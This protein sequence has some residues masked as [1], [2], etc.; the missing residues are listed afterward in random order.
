M[1]SEDV[2]ASLAPHLSEID[3]PKG[4]NIYEKGGV[5]DTMYIIVEGQ[6]RVHDGENNIL[7]LLGERDF[8][9]ELTTLDPQPHAASTTANEDTRLLGL[10]RD[11]LYELMSDYP[12]ML[13][14]IVQ[15][16][17]QRLRGKQESS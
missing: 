8:F 10:N 7:V 13:R 14:S 9:G 2:L 17:C 6:V 12:E 1:S 11:I 4:E 3:V 15:I 5:G 16:L